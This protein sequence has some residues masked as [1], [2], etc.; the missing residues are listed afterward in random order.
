MYVTWAGLADAMRCSRLFQTICRLDAAH[1]RLRPLDD[2][3]RSSRG[4][5]GVRLPDDFRAKSLNLLEQPL[6]CSG[7]TRQERQRERKATVLVASVAGLKG[8]VD[9][10][11]FQFQA[12]PSV[13]RTQSS[14]S[15]QE[16]NPFS[17]LSK[18]CASGHIECP[19]DGSSVASV[20]LASASFQFDLRQRGSKFSAFNSPA[21]EPNEIIGAVGVLRTPGCGLE[22]VALT[23]A[24]SS[25]SAAMLGSHAKGNKVSTGRSDMKAS[26]ISSYWLSDIILGQRPI[27]TEFGGRAKIDFFVWTF[28]V[29][30]GKVYSWF[31]PC[32]EF[33]HDVRISDYIC[34]VL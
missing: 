28:Q 18:Q 14:E 4:Q 22:A 26:E 21:T 8:T 10:L 9:Y 6:P 19:V 32:L 33:M 1:Q 24:G 5:W 25:R 13:G 34:L 30:N 2:N 17:V 31:V 16:H 27:S 15:Y 11:A 23:S 12:I 7:S 29:A 3:L 20:F